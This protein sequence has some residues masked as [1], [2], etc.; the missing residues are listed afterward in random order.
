[1]KFEWKLFPLQRKLEW[2]LDVARCRLALL[3]RDSE[4]AASLL[5]AMERSQVQQAGLAS[6]A[7]RGRLDP[8]LHDQALGYL[9]GM[10]ARIAQARAE[11]VRIDEELAT[12]RDECVRCQRR[13]DTLDVAHDRALAQHATQAQR[14]AGRDADCDWLARGGGVR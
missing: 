4:H 14:R 7:M 1:M 13:L 10:E 11:R 6:Q 9:A 12:V 8:T 5:Q 2:D 3:L